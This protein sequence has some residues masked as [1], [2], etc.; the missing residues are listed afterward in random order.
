PPLLFIILP[1]TTLCRSD[2]GAGS[3]GVA[4][5][6]ETTT[7][8]VSAQDMRFVPDTVTVPVGDR[9]VIELTNDDPTT[10]HDLTVGGVT[11]DRLAP[12][13]S[14]T[15][16]VGVV[17]EDLDGWCTVA[18]HR[19]MGMVFTVLAEGA[20]PGSTAGTDGA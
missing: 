4:A 1:Y 2:G 7:V 5:T 10:V 14:Q 11:S 9:L 15:L 18:G 8:Q 20:A 16:D 19:Q 13:E 3:A 12:G 6:G 17:G